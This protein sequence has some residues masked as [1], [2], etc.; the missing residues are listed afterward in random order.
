M[1]RRS[2]SRCAHTASMAPRSTA[3]AGRMTTAGVRRFQARRGLAVDGVAGPATRRALG[4][5]GRP[6]LGTRVIRAGMRGWDV[7]GL[8][9]LLGRQGFPVGGADGG[10][11]PRTDAALRRFQAWAGLGADGLA[12][13]ATIARLRRAPPSSPL[14]FAMP[15]AAPA[16]DRFGPRGNGF[17]TGVDF[18][19]G[20]GTP[21]AAAGRG[22]VSFA[23]WSSGGYGKLVVIEHRL[24]MTSWY[25]HLSRI[26]VR[27]RHVR[28]RGHAGRPRRLDRPHDRPAP[29]LRDAPARRR[30]AAAL[31]AEW[32]LDVAPRPAAGAAGGRRPE[33]I[34]LGFGVGTQPGGDRGAVRGRAGPTSAPRAS[35]ARARSPRPTRGPRSACRPSPPTTPGR[36]CRPCAGSG[37]PPSA[38]ARRAPR[39]TSPAAC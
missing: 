17:H 11:G 30:R 14:V 29:A 2:R 19:V 16:G 5:R 22:C 21:V 1:L 18:P 34:P 10:L 37:R 28:R 39:R 3:C 12:G 9:F 4:R 7:A 38:R 25:A 33:G 24:G 23:G 35:G 27:A 13:P 31:L 26:R 32:V 6:R 15:V 36:P 20:H 8:Q